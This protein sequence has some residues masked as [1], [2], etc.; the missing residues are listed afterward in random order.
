[1]IK[2]L[3]TGSSGFIGK[4]IKEF[5]IKDNEYEVFSPS[6]KDLNLLNKI[7]V[8]KYLNE[9]KIDWI[10]HSANHHWHPRDNKSKR[11]D[12]QLKNNLLM[13]LNLM[14]C[15]SLYQNIIYFGSGGEVPREYWNKEI[16]ESDI[17][18]KL[19]DDPYGIS[20]LL[21]D[22]FSHKYKNAYNLRLFGVCG[23]YDDWR[24][25]F[26]SNMCALAILNNDLVINQDAIFDYLYVAD[27]YKILKFFI[28]KQPEVSDYN[29]STGQG[30]KLTEIARKVK[31]YSNRNLKVLLKNKEMGSTYIGSNK[32]FLK[33]SPEFKFTKI[34]KIIE[35]IYEYL[36]KNEGTLNI[37]EINI[38]K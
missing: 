15:R 18:K 33:L 4:S 26:I 27:L 34:D 16:T 17:G 3:I 13:F 7:D 36:N 20:K 8:K 25:R 2:I 9:N 21:M 11:I 23:E 32:K 14:D 24:F 1:V 12:D 29:I 5:F 37:N 38:K 19:P 22:C 10:I 31:K 35:N 28:N 30:I 6:S